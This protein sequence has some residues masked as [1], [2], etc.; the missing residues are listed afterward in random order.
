MSVIERISSGG[1]WEEPIGYS[2]AVRAGDR[3]LVSGCTATVG[4]AV[5]HVGDAYGQA[6][7]AIAIALDALAKAGARPEQVVRT[8]MFV[9]N[10]SDTDAVGR[11]HGDAFTDVRPAATMVLVAG[12][13]HPDHLVEIEMEAYVG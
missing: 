11:A 12:L 1:P 3:V 9:V 13:I 4:G 8:R 5:V 6:S 2:R 10:R 7:E